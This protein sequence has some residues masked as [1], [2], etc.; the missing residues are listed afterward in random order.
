MHPNAESAYLATNYVITLI[1]SF[2]RNN[3]AFLS[4][5]SLLTMFPL[6]LPSSSG[7]HE[8][9]PILRGLISNYN[10]TILFR[11][12]PSTVASLLW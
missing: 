4:Y 10:L 6:H 3:F 8:N 9:V 11:L 1:T 7:S 12:P 2:P 5:R